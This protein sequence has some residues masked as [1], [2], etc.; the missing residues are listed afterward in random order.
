MAKFNAEDY[1]NELLSQSNYL[2]VDTTIDDRCI[3]EAKN[4]IEF[5]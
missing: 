1:I 2:P 4:C 5:F 3:P